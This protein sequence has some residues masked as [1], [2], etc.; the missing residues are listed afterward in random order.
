MS[1]N[2]FSSNNISNKISS[3][4]IWNHPFVCWMMW[5]GARAAAVSP[6]AMGRATGGGRASQLSRNTA[7]RQK[8]CCHYYDKT[9]LLEV[10]TKHLS[11]LYYLL[12]LLHDSEWLFIRLV[13][14][15]WLQ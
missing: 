5:L 10:K 9:L 1:E 7:A 12:L 15:N 4:N 11:H 8:L 13:A 14:M 3:N 2:T 6:Q